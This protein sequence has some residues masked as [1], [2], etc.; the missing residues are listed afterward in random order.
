MVEAVQKHMAETVIDSHT[1]MILLG[2]NEMLE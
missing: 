2:R 1:L